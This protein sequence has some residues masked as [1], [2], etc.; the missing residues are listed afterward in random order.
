MTAP[1]AH[2]PAAD[3]GHDIVTLADP[4]SVLPPPIEKE[5]EKKL[6]PFHRS[7]WHGPETVMSDS[8]AVATVSMTT[9]PASLETSTVGAPEDAAQLE[10]LRSYT[11]RLMSRVEA[12]LGTRLDWLAV[13]HWDTDNPHTHVVLRGRD[14]T[15]RDLVIAGDYIARGM[16][17]RAAEVATAWLGP[18]SEREC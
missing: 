5:P 12:D 11:R 9:S 10:D 7:A 16:R 4:N 3:C 18:R 15:E 17:R 2:A 8:G 14:E 1:M 13:D 6:R